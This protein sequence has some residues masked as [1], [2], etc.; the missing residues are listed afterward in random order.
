MKTLEEMEAYIDAFDYIDDTQE[1]LLSVH[2]EATFYFWDGHTSSIRQNLKDCIV[3]YMTSFGEHITWGFDPLK[4]WKQKPFEKLPSFQKVL[5][6]YSDPDDAIEW[7]VASDI[8]NDTDF[9]NHYNLR[10]LTARAW[11]IEDISVLTF[12]INRADFFNKEK[13]EIILNLFDYCIHKL[14]PYQALMGWASAFGYDKDNRDM[15]ILD[16]A[17]HFFGINIYDVWDTC[18]MHHGIRTI[19]WYTYISDD[20]A[21]RIGGRTL[22]NEQVLQH[23]LTSKD[24]PNGILL[25]AEDSPNLLPIDEPIPATYL[26]INDICRPMRNGNFGSIGAG[27]DDGIGYQSFNEYFTDLWM[28]RFDNPELWKRFPQ[29]TDVVQSIAISLKTN[30]TC[31]V[32]GRYRYEEEYDYNRNQKVYKESDNYRDNDCRQY[33]ILKKGDKAPY[34]IRMDSDGHIVEPME[35]SWTLFEE[36]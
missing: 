9:P 22:L 34:Y 11:E 3:Q 20:L 14:N 18:Q 8:I 24:Y 1:T 13:H 27:Y 10:C 4:D 21:Q 29:P 28:R 35:I 2:L 5:D 31:S 6:T 33:I 25:I 17:K 30:E 23:D 16:Q 19:D 12:R 7:F 32:G 26:K 15:D 36:F